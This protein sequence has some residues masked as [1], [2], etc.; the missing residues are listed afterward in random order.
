MSA[1]R[2]YRFMR[3]QITIVSCCIFCCS[4]LFSRRFI[5][6]RSNKTQHVPGAPPL[7]LLFLQTAHYYWWRQWQ[8]QQ[9]Q[10]M[11]SGSKHNR[12]YLYPAPTLQRTPALQNYFLSVSRWQWS[13]AEPNWT[14]GNEHNMQLLKLFQCLQFNVGTYMKWIRNDDFLYIFYIWICYQIFIKCKRTY[15]HLSFRTLT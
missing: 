13:N 7:L 2:P 12:H 15:S 9:Q 11:P 10:I 5:I 4:A 8:H 3:T 14:A 1:T 6:F